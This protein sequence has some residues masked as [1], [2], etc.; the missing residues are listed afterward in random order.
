M[1]YSDK[2]NE[3]PW[4]DSALLSI[5]IDRKNPGENDSIKL[6][7]KWPD[8]NE[9][10][11]VFNDCYFL[12]AKM[13]FGIVAEESILR[14]DCRRECEEISVVKSK[15]SLLGSKLDNLFCYTINTNSTNSS[16]KIL[17]LSMDVI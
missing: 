8:G 13:N 1:N 10:T 16:L 14:A 5:E 9:S 6:F 11:I 4:H 3:L 17:A 12:D 2:F 7:I 15:W